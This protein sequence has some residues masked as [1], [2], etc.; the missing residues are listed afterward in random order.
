MG[1]MH[2]FPHSR[3]F[4]SDL[5][6][7]LE[8]F[9]CVKDLPSELEKFKVEMLEKYGSLE[10]FI[11]EYFNNLDLQDEV[12]KKI[13][14]LV[15]DG[16]LDKI[17]TMHSM[18]GYETVAV[19]KKE[20]NLVS[21]HVVQTLGYYGVNDGGGALYIVCDEIPETFYEVL[22]NGKYA[23]LITNNTYNVKQFGA[24]GDAI[25][26]DTIAFKKVAELI[27]INGGTMYIPQGKYIITDT[28]EF[29]S[30]K[31]LSFQIIGSENSVLLYSSENSLFKCTNSATN[32]H[33][34]NFNIIGVG[35]YKKPN[36]YCFDFNKIT[37]SVFKDIQ[38]DKNEGDVA[39]AGVFTSAINGNLD[40]IDEVW[41]Y[42]ITA[43]INNSGV[44]FNIG[45]GSSV[46]FQAVRVYSGGYTTHSVGI[47]CRGG[48]GGLAIN[49]CDL[50]SCDIGLV[51]DNK[52][53]HNN[54][55]I[56]IT[57][58]YFDKC[59]VG[60]FKY[61]TSY[62]SIVGLWAASCS[63]AGFTIDGGIVNIS[64]G[65]CFNNGIIGDDNGDG[66]VLNGGELQCSNVHFRH[67]KGIALRQTNSKVGVCLITNCRFDNIDGKA[68]ETVGENY[69]DSCYFG[70]NINT[71]VRTL[72]PG[73]VIT[74][75]HGNEPNAGI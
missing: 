45:G 20:R 58:S 67:I 75:W 66:I 22:E 5:R 37:D 50:I 11:K 44:G 35:T 74:N 73:L 26:D 62:L 23:M 47:Y 28:I 49:S 8:L 57:N 64:G 6:E 10:N 17:I 39:V 34:E 59:R 29:N 68:L 31:I 9:S 72:T 41:F 19:M 65:T 27:A 48:M 38:I 52:N 30:K 32:V 43:L 63:H 42:N 1:F 53:N 60:I 51:V 36:T 24:K 46:W 2:E 61:D 3:T 55:E 12:N 71:I 25:N 4:D 56:F 40:D 54:R 70:E 14:E 33:I 69:V 18:H 13:D 15:L 16:T 7:I 21:G